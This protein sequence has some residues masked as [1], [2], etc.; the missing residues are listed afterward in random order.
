M[1]IETEKA[2]HRFYG[3][4]PTVEHCRAPVISA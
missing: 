4:F 3:P 1:I 2:L